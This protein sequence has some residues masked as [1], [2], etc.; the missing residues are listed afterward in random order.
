MKVQY[1]TQNGRLTAEFEADTQVEL[2]KQLA[3]FQEVFENTTCSDGKESSD[4]V[5]FSVRE[6]EGNHFFE[7]VCVDESKPNLRWAKKKYG[8]HKGKDQTLFPKADWAKWNPQTEK[9]EPLNQKAKTR[10]SNTEN[11]FAPV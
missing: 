11:E 10:S 3:Q 1:T 9:E 5:R 6:V 7:L 8:Q 2:F 4:L